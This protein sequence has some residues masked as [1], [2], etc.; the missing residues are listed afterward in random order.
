MPVVREVD[1]LWRRVERALLNRIAYR[2]RELLA[3]HDDYLALELR[4]NQTLAYLHR[5]WDRAG[6]E[7]ASR[8]A[9]RAANE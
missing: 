8:L 9:Q 1:E 5:V 3:L 2:E 4:H 7:R 6:I